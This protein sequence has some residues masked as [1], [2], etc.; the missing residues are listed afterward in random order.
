MGE[1]HLPL[2]PWPFLSKPAPK[3]RAHPVVLVLE[4]QADGE[5]V[6]RKSKM[7]PVYEC[8]CLSMEKQVVCYEIDRLDSGRS[9]AS[10]RDD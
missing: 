8:V 2:S 10:M 7:S 9:I 1:A 4:K 3:L 5:R 6:G